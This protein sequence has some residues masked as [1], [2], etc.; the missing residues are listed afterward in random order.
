MNTSDAG[1]AAI[2][3]REGLELKAYPDPGTGGAPWTIGY[4]HTGRDVKPGM[5]IDENTAEALLV[6][7]LASREKAVGRLVSVDL[8]QGQFDALVSLVYNIGE[9]NFATSTLLRKLNAGD[10]EGAADEFLR[11]NRAAGR[12]MKGLALRR[13]DER[14]QFLA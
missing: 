8:T 13:E 9:R 12:V 5:E 11:W 6:G 4:G 2:K 7:D 14:A 3:R 1:I 10:Y